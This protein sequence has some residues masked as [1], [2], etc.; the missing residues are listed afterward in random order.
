MITLSKLRVGDFKKL[1]SKKVVQI[2][3]IV[4]LLAILLWS[5][6]PM[7][8]NPAR[9][10]D[11]GSDG[12]LLS[13]IMNHR[14]VSF[15]ANIFYPNKN[16]LAYSDM[17]KISGLITWPL[18]KVFGNPGVA[19]GVALILGQ[20]STGLILFLWWKQRFKNGWAAVIGVTVFLLSQIRFEYQVHLQMW[21]MQY[22]LLGSWL[23]SSWF[24]DKK[25]WKLILGSVILGLQMWESPLP[26]LFATTVLIV[27]AIHKS[28][29]PNLKKLLLPL[30]IFGIIVFPVVWAYRGASAEFG[31]VRGIREAAH[32]SI[33]VN[34]LWGKFWSPGLFVLLVVALVSPTSVLPLNLRGRKQEGDI[35]WLWIVLLLGLVM[36]LGPVLKWQDKTV[37]IWNKYP[38]PL[39]YA[40]AYYLVPGMKA[41]RVPSRWLWLSGFAASG[42][43]AAGLSNRGRGI[44]IGMVACLII[45]IIGGTKILKTIDLSN[46]DKIPDV[47]KWLAGQNINCVIEVPVYTWGGPGEAIETNR[48]YDS[49]FHKK[50]LVN[51]Y[52]GFTP[53]RIIDLAGDMTKQLEYVDQCEV[54]VHKNETEVRTKGKIVY[55]DEK[56]VVY[57]NH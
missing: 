22:W 12:K 53:P 46:F 33:S 36:S 27:W 4:T 56:T 13:W 1:R 30:I 31:Y 10:A 44:S 16:V 54:I 43:I 20:V 50:N 49:L 3:Q 11:I 47:Y 28:Q 55:E 14:G 24:T 7:V 48:M 18:V 42:L 29:I 25:N 35:K 51:G 34:D 26:I 8:V 38:I 23:V 45:G 52:S 57:S 21:G 5:V 37:K 40:V 17:L 9:V 19:S 15:D 32:N 2:L 6:W 39:P 41:F